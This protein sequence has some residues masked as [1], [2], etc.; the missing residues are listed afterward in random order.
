MPMH[1]TDASGYCSIMPIVGNLRALIRSTIVL[2]AGLAIVT[3][4]ACDSVATAP[5][6]G[7][8]PRQVTVVGAG[9]VEGTPDTLTASVA[10]S[11]QASDATTAMNQTSDRQQA[12]ID[13]LVAGGVDNADISTTTVSLQPQFGTDGV[14]V[15]GYQ[16]SN[17]IDVKIRDLSAAS[18][19]LALIVNIGGNTTRINSV[20]F[21]I[22]DDSQLVKDA[23]ARAFEDAKDR[24]Q[25]YS[26][27][28]GLKLGKVISISE[29]SDTAPPQP[30]PVPT[31][32]AMASDVPLA[33]GQQ[34][35][36]FA[37]TAVWE[38]G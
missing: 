1:G 3:L 20:N 30:V 23:R 7:L 2:L 27:L 28:S 22:D 16:A 9:K 4:S 21:S 8:N 19:T 10:I 15:A 38:L 31:P 14:T 24:A 36:N 34:T 12:V 26:D 29:S 11:F 17:G 32:R 5:A 25:Q 18:R 13:A 6:P 33:P 37:V 35:V